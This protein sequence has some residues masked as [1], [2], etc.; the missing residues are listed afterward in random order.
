M[1]IRPLLFVSHRLKQVA[2]LRA[3]TAGCERH[4]HR[5][6]LCVNQIKVPSEQTSQGLQPPPPKQQSSHIKAK[7]GKM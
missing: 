1:S 6:Q 7:L 4:A 3:K 2:R 5:R